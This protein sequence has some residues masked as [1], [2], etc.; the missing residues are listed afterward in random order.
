VSM[1]S[2]LLKFPQLLCIRKFFSGTCEEA[3]AFSG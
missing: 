1:C 2:P 3:T